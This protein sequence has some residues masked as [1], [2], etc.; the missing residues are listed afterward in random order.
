MDK[1]L[2]RGLKKET[3]NKA[4]IKMLPSYVTSTPN[5]SGKCTQFCLCFMLVNICQVVQISVL[6]A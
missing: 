3:N 4:E 6:V 5:G 1:E 2:E